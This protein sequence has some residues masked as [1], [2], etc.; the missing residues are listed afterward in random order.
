MCSEW[1]RTT[2]R[3]I[4]AIWG[5]WILCFSLLS[6]WLKSCVGLFFYVL[7]CICVNLALANIP[8]HIMN[9]HCRIAWALWS[10]Y[11]LRWN[12]FFLGKVMYWEPIC[13]WTKANM[14]ECLWRYMRNHTRMFSYCSTIGG[15]IVS[16]DSFDFFQM[17][18]SAAFSVT[19]WNL[20]T[21]FKKTAKSKV[22]KPSIWN[23]VPLDHFRIGLKL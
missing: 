16:V 22:L 12:Y 5:I 18:G 7:R 2:Q 20:Y 10:N 11:Q 23:L 13:V 3:E 21:L 15:D 1:L 9:F 19:T 14:L 17:W 4:D 6:D 8:G